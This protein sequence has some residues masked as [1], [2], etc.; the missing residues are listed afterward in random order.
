MKKKELGF[1]VKLQILLQEHNNV[2]Q[3]IAEAFR[4]MQEIAQ[5]LTISERMI[6][7]MAKI[8]GRELVATTVAETIRAEDAEREKLQVAALEK[9][10]A[11]GD[12][13]AVARVHAGCLVVLQNLAPAEGMT[14]RSTA[15]FGELREPIQAA[16]VGLGVGDKFQVPDVGEFE[17][18]GIYERVQ[19]ESPVAVPTPIDTGAATIEEGDVSVSHVPPAPEVA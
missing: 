13:V 15:M 19:K 16:V 12:A 6:D 14:G 9:N 3:Q 1:D 18:A 8:C 4:V 17:V 5:R 2:R 7:A 10:L 11:D